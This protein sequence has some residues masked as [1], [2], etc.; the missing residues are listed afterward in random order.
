MFGR[1]PGAFG[2]F[3]I[4]A[5]NLL[6]AASLSLVGCLASRSA[7]HLDR[8]FAASPA[9]EVLL[10]PVVDGRPEKFDHVL[11]SRNVRDAMVMFLREKKYTVTL[12]RDFAINP[13]HDLN[14]LSIEELASL[15]PAS[16]R[17][18]VMLV[19]VERLDRELEELGE[20]YTVRVSG[21]LVDPRKP[22]LLWQDRAFGTSSLNG[23]LTVLSRGSGQYEA[24]VN[25]V[26]SLLVSLPEAKG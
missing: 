15:V 9:R 3:R 4:P 14:T 25:A 13:T 22:A 6:L 2:P 26:R 18:P 5:V 21:F 7:I 16:A 19:Q 1:I 8:D 12:E 24:S 17:Q 10:V 11:V 23:L 20:T